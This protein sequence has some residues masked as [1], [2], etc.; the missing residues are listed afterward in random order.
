MQNQGLKEQ[1]KEFFKY[2]ILAMI[3]VVP[4]RIYIAQPFIVKGVSM[5]PTF[6]TGDYL[7]VDEISYHSQDPQRGEVFVFKYPRDPKFDYIKR[8]IGIPGDTIK[9]ENGKVTITTKEGEEIS[10][11]EPYVVF[12][13]TETKSRILGEGEYFAMGDNRRE[14]YDSRE[15][16][17]VPRENIIGR[18]LIR[19]WPINQFGL[20]P[21]SIK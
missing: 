10:T 9:I 16:G 17:P 15:W 6:E 14:S 19:L 12:N 21:G 1:F 8:I 13:S 7:I 18:V 20:F 4:I 2:F 3:I 5:S 11:N